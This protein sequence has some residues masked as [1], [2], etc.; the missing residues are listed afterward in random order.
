MT[1]GIAITWHIKFLY[2]R[3][4][5]CYACFHKGSI[6]FVNNDIKV[7]TFDYTRFYA[8]RYEVH[9]LYHVVW[10]V[11][12]P[13]SCHNKR[14]ILVF[15]M[16]NFISIGFSTFV[17]FAF[18]LPYLGRG[19]LLCDVYRCA[20]LWESVWVME[21]KVS[22]VWRYSGILYCEPYPTDNCMGACPL[23][24]VTLIKGWR[25]SCDL[26]TLYMRMWHC[27]GLRGSKVWLVD[28]MCIMWIK[29]CIAKYLLQ[30][31]TPPHAYVTLHR[32]ERFSCVTL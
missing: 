16:V 4:I 6:L 9:T 24:C 32:V 29:A 18:S 8:L 17:F 26:P 22:S 27:I 21:E 10:V 2:K 1:H 30:S 13:F 31:A 20:R 28:K 12:N 14:H 25:A 7:R 19:F 5:P 3:S 23:L 15:R 11:D